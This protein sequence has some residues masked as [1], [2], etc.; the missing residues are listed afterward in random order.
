MGESMCAHVWLCVCM[1]VWMWGIRIVKNWTVDLGDSTGK[2]FQSLPENW[3][4]RQ[5]YD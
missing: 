2:V 3:Q 5:V 1:V 4:A